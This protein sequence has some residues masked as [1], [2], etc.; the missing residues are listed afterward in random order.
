MKTILQAYLYL[1]QFK[2]RG[3]VLFLIDGLSTT[4]FA[5]I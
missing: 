4:R 3:F 2:I 5:S 1:G